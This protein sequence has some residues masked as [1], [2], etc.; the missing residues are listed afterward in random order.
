[1]LPA[2]LVFG[3]GLSATVAPVTATA[4]AAADPRHSGVASGIN[5]AVAR[6]AQLVAVAVLP[7]AAGLTGGD[8]QNPAALEDGFRT[9]MVI[10]AA[11]AALG[12]LLAFT[13]I[14]DD[15]LET[16]PSGPDE[17]TPERA[18]TDRSCAVA[19]TPLRPAREARCVAARERV[20]GAGSR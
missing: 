20:A 6:T 10:S 19:G 4:L 16:V 11:L 9:A 15:V 12:G 14:S 7:L 18:A 5:N 1:V 8:F 13:T 3:L 2:V 17:G